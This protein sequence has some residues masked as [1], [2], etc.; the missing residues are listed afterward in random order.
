MRAFQPHRTR[1]ISPASRKS[2]AKYPTPGMP[3]DQKKDC[4]KSTPNRK[5]HQREERIN[6]SPVCSTPSTAGRRFVVQ[7]MRVHCISIIP[8]FVFQLTP[9][10][11]PP[12]PG[13]CYVADMDCTHL[14]PDQRHDLVGKLAGHQDA[15]GKIIKRMKSRGWYTSDPV[16]NALIAAEAS[17]Q[18]ARSAITLADKLPAPERVKTMAFQI[19]KQLGAVG[20]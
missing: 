9:I 6:L 17:I 3:G 1:G 12:A 15:I 18:A 16:Y 7:L 13:P 10:P 8:P 20:Q 5:P 19:P 4:P 2:S 11:I 14:T